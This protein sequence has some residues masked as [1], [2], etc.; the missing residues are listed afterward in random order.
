[1]YL[2]SVLIYFYM[3]IF[4]AKTFVHHCACHSIAIDPLLFKS[5]LLKTIRSR[6]PSI[7]IPVCPWPSL[8]FPNAHSPLLYTY[9]TSFY[10]ISQKELDLSVLSFYLNNF[11]RHYEQ[12]PKLHFSLF[13]LSLYFYIYLPVSVFHSLF[14]CLYLSLPLF[15]VLFIGFQFPQYFL[16]SKSL[17]HLT[18]SMGGCDLVLICDYLSTYQS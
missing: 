18:I 1:M 2:A 11:W 8:T 10:G 17:K 14:L 9:P 3:K 15:S 13:P 4:V 5:V 6:T 12:R 7:I 16:S